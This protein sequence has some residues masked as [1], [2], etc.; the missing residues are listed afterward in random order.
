MRPYIYFLLLFITISFSA[1]YPS[2]PEVSPFVGEW[3]SKIGRANNLERVRITNE[4]FFLN[5]DLIPD[6]RYIM[7]DRAFYIEQIWKKKDADDYRMECTYLYRNDTLFIHDF[8]YESLISEYVHV[9]F[10]R[11]EK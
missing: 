2:D 3:T 10:T 11:I 9:A 6:Y 8:Y 4:Y 1:C 5:A 7:D